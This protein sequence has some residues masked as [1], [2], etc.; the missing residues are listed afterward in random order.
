V[1]GAVTGPR[2]TPLTTLLLGR[3]DAAGHLRLVAR[4]TP[5]NSAARR[6]LGQQ[7]ARSGP[8]HPWHGRHFSAGWGSRGELECRPVQPDLVP[9]F[10]ADT[11][12][13]AGRYRHPVQCVRLR[14][15][16]TPQQTPP[17]TV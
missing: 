1:I 15:D 10:V 17:F 11:A 2:K 16:L 5:P 7:L 13:D 14:D 8:Q 4:T 9:E 3:H 6:H 12:I